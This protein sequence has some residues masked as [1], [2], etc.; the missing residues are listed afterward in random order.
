[1]ADAYDAVILAGGSAR[2]MGGVDKPALLVGDASILDRVLRSVVGATSVV[3]VG[4]RRTTSRDVTWCREEPPGGGPVAA[5]AA[6]LAEVAAH[7]VVVLAGDLPFV[8]PNAVDTLLDAAGGHDGALLIDH[9]GRDQLLAG[10]WRTEALRRAMPDKAAGARLGPVLL[11]LNPVRVALEE[12]SHVP[13][14]W[15][16]CDTDEDV[17]TAR[18]MT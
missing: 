10:T 11:A 13:P 1:V 5:L 3:V 17:A 6:G 12:A 18:G 9:D 8:T 14:A 7:R 15:F 2:R 4:P 16:D